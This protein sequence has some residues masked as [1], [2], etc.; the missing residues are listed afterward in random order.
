MPHE[1]CP[2]RFF[3]PMGTKF[4]LGLAPGRTGPYKFFERI[5]TFAMTSDSQVETQ[6][7][8]EPGAVTKTGAKNA[9][10]DAQKYYKKKS[11]PEGLKKMEE[12]DE[13]FK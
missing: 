3:G 2:L 6:A 11:D 12:G 10:S 7:S 1:S 13:A 8:A 5:G 9:K 4:F